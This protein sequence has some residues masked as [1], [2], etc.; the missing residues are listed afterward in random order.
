MSEVILVSKSNDMASSHRAV[1]ATE[2]ILVMAMGV[3]I[4]T[5]AVENVGRS[6]AV[7]CI[8]NSPFHPGSMDI[9]NMAM[10]IMG[11]HSWSIFRHIN[12]CG[13]HKINLVDIMLDFWGIGS[14]SMPIQ[15]HFRA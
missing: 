3:H 14:Q 2:H 5:L 6:S 11:E 4:H 13:R 8:V 10:N 12:A 1:S 7:S 9:R 15:K